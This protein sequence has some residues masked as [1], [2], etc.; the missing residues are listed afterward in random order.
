MFHRLVRLAGLSLCVLI[1]SCSIESPKAPNWTVPINVPLLDSTYTVTELVKHYENAFIFPDGLLGLR[2]NSELDTTRLGDYLQLADI[3]DVFKISLSDFYLN[4]LTADVDLFA[5]LNMNPAVAGLHGQQ[6]TVQAFTFK[7]IPSNNLQHPEFRSAS[8]L[9]GHATVQIFNRL[10]M[11]L[12]NVTVKLVQESTREIL[13]R[14]DIIAHLPAKSTRLLEMQIDTLTI[15]SKAYWLISGQSPGSPSELV[16]IDVHEGV[17]LALQLNQVHVSRL[18]AKLPAFSIDHEMSINM[19][20]DFI[21][22]KL[23][24]KKGSMIFDISNNLPV[25]LDLNLSSSHIFNRAKADTLF[26]PVQLEAYGKFRHVFDLANYE[27]NLLDKQ[28][29]THLLPFHIQGGMVNIPEGLV[30]LNEENSIQVDIALRDIQFGQFSGLLDHYQIAMDSTRTAID[31]EEFGDLKGIKVDDARL[32]VT[33]FSTLNIPVQFVGNIYSLNKKGES[34]SLYLNYPLNLAMDRR[35]VATVLPPFTPAN[36]NILLFINLNPHQL[37]AAG[38]AFIGDGK[39][40]GC[41]Y[42]D[43]YIRAE[44]AFETAAKAIFQEKRI[45]M[46]TTL[47]H[48]LPPGQSRSSRSNVMELESDWT[49]QVHDLSFKANIGNHM[50]VGGQMIIKVAETLADLAA[51]PDLILG[52]VEIGPALLDSGGRVQSAISKETLL[53]IPADKISLFKNDSPHTRELYVA[54]DIKI[55]GSNEQM[56][57]IF[58][59]DYI[60]I[61]AALQVN[62]DVNDER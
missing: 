15:P 6:T 4:N 46:D 38:H 30:D 22:E 48:I 42:A 18:N 61:Q 62:M 51:E 12:E 25:A 44:F 55:N 37:L 59:S 40:T 54:I 52:P 11:D 1:V 49:K 56:V 60:N 16:M 27:I 57:Q 14:S 43:D 17:E 26:M 41:V 10:P 13:M 33:L 5:L 45:D 50:P 21:I 8:I 47:L 29:L 34:T 35:E 39:K 31:L 53:E 9:Y 58:G 28:R 7:N 20:Q 19:G 23:S 36:S 3:S 32:Y 2:I 24:L